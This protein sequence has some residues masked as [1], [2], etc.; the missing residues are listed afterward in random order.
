MIKGEI[1][2]KII[3]SSQNKVIKHAKSLQF[4]KYRDAAGEYLLE[5]I[6]LLQEAIKYDADISHIFYHDE[7]LGNPDIQDIIDT[8]IERKIPVYEMEEKLFLDISETKTSQGVIAIGKKRDYDMTSLIKQKC[9]NIVMLEEVQDPGNVGTIIRTADACGFDMAILSKGCADIYSGKT[10]RSTMGS[11]FHMPIIPDMDFE[12]MLG[13]LE[14]VG[15]LTL[16]AAPHDGMPCY[17]IRYKDENAIIVGN[18]SKGLTGAVMDK[19]S[20]K[21]NIPM[22][23]R[24]ES[25]NAGVAASI[26]MYEIMR[27]RLAR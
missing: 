12:H 4:K 15:A 3:T 9:F 21:V 18:E 10:I 14:S 16:A 23:G 24:A 27:H 5:G 22:I 7:V 17:D 1:A 6:K 20:L 13:I 19:A 11:L 26:L 8:C 2:V 25:L